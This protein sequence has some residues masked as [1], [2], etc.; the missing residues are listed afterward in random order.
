MEIYN[1][2]KSSHT[3]EVTTEKNALPVTYEISPEIDNLKIYTQF[4]NRFPHLSTYPKR[5][6][7]IAITKLN[8]NIYESRHYQDIVVSELVDYYDECCLDGEEA[9]EEFYRLEED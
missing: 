6:K 9:V 4:D 8:S 2:D 1:R 3:A 7:D 5:F